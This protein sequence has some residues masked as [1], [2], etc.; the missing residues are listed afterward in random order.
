[1]ANSRRRRSLSFSRVESRFIYWS[2]YERQ[3]PSGAKD[4][5]VCL[6]LIIKDLGF[7]KLR[8]LSCDAKHCEYSTHSGHCVTR[9]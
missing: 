8:V 7:L 2:V 9:L 5:E 6:Q 4:G 1:M 3:C